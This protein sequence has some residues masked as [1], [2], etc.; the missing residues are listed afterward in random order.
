MQ[1][2]DILMEEHRVI[3]RVL[4][5]LETGATRLDQGQP[6]RPGFFL[7]GAQFVKGFADGCHHRKEEGVLFETMINYGMPRQGGPVAVMLMEHEQGRVFTRAMHAAAERLA[8]GDATA[9]AAVVQNA[10]GYVALLRQHIAK[11]D[12][13]LY[14]MADQVIPAA[15]HAA[16]LAGFEHVEHEE[17]GAGVHE[18]YLA[19]AN[20]LER[21]VAG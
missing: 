13:I 15:D 2:T 1:A 7:D 16:V 6:V 11:E 9:G 14:P 12:T 8:A 4:T 20:A 21:E 18:K 5:A 17:T 19:L 3:E 10:R